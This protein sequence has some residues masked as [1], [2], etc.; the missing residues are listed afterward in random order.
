MSTIDALRKLYGQLTPF[1]RA[2]MCIEAV[3]R[4]DESALDALEPPTLWDA[5]HGT[6][7]QEALALLAFMAT[8]DSLRAESAAWA[9]R[10]LLSIE[11]H[12]GKKADEAKLGKYLEMLQEAERKQFAWMLALETLDNETGAV[13]IAIVDIFAN[14]H[15]AKTLEAAKGRDIEFADELEY[16]RDAWRKIAHSIAGAPKLEDAPTIRT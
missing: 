13:C 1:E 8:A 14:G 11:G 12:K 9:G 16:L 2:V 10:L 4:R 3:A 5:F 6:K 7:A 15:A